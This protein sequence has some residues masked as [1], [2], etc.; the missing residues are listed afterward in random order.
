MDGATMDAAERNHREVENRVGELR[1]P[2]ARAGL[3]QYLLSNLVHLTN[4]DWTGVSVPTPNATLCVEPVC[5]FNTHHVPLRNIPT[6]ARPSP[7]KSAGA[8][9]SPAMP[10]WKA[11]N[12]S[13]DRDKYQTPSRYTPRSILP[14][15]SKSAGTSLSVAIPKFV[16]AS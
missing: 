16:A 9:I 2:G 14:S 10:N 8:G 11:V 5:R 4:A 7:S 1:E 6:S 15:P 3:P 13:C 12:P